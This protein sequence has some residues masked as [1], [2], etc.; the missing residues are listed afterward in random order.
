M[1]LNCQLFKEAKHIAST[2]Y[3]EMLPAIQQQHE[4]HLLESKNIKELSSVNSKL[5]LKAF[6][7]SNKWSEAYELVENDPEEKRRIAMQHAQLLIKKSPSEA[8]RTLLNKGYIICDEKLNFY[9]I[10]MKKY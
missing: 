2:N 3:R 8:L 5:A 9:K 6:I 1:A 7:D 4:D 10:L